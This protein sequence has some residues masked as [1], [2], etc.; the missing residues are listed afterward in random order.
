M[1][2]EDRAFKQALKLRIAQRY[3]EERGLRPFSIGALYAKP[4]RPPVMS[5]NMEQLQRV[6]LCRAIG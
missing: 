1:T 5:Q 2:D 4:Y 3:L 6:L